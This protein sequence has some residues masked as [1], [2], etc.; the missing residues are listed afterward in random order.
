MP[1][2][3]DQKMACEPCIRGHR[4]TKCNHANERLMVPVRKPGRPLSTSPHPPARGSAGSS[5]T[6]AVPRK[7]K[8]DCR[9]SGD[10]PATESTNIESKSNTKQRLDIS[11]CPPNKALTINASVVA[12]D[13]VLNR[14]SHPSN[15]IGQLPIQIP[16]AMPL[17]GIFQ[18]CSQPTTF[19]Y[20]TPHEFHISTLQFSHYRQITNALHYGHPTLLPA[21]YGLP[22]PLGFA[23]VRAKLPMPH[24]TS[25]SCRLSDSCQC[26]GCATQPCNN[27][28]NDNV[29]PAWD[30]MLDVCGTTDVVKTTHAATQHLKVAKTNGTEAQDN[31]SQVGSEDG[32]SS[33]APKKLSDA[34][35]GL[36]DE[37]PLSMI[38]TVSVTYQPDRNAYTDETIACPCDD[39][40]QCLLDM[41]RCVFP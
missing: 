17:P 30:S 12:N 34:V 1:L 22:V 35:L 3:N 38:D 14:H 11:G 10:P 19:T 27:A 24:S 33:D 5:A 15:A 29:Q 40:F 21:A 23:P 26:I 8:C 7:R 9:L 31:E 13:E 37:P 41:Q 25:Y 16:M 6:F 2:I 4:S 39:D 36:S 18:P 20:P 28:A 32:G